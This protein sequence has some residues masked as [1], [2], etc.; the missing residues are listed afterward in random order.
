MAPGKYRHQLPR[1]ATRAYS[2]PLTRL[3]VACLQFD[4]PVLPICAATYTTVM[5]SE[6]KP[7]PATEPGS[8]IAWDRAVSLMLFRYTSR[9][10]PRKYLMLLEHSGNGLVWLFLAVTVWCLP[11]SVQQRCAVSNFLLAFVVDL[12]LVGTLKAICQRPRPIYNSSGDFMLV[13][14]VDQYSFPSGH[15]SRC[16]TFPFLQRAST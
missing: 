8:L 1:Q 3:A 4:H 10:I 2:A 11:I 9:S 15:A 14:A 12:I 6:V 7:V 13:V 5:T 16:R